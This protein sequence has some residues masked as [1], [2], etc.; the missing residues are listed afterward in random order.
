MIRSFFLLSSASLLLTIGVLRAQAP[1]APANIPYAD[2]R[3]ILDVLRSDLLPPELRAATPV[4]RQAI[5]PDWVARRDGDIRARL[6]RADEDSLLNLLLLGTTFTRHP[7]VTD[8][9]AVRTREAALERLA[10]RLDDLADA[11]TSPRDERLRFARD[12][13]LGRGI[14]AD[15]AQGKSQIR[16]YLLEI[17]ERVAGETEGFARTAAAMS[18]LDDPVARLALSATNYRD[19]G[20]SSD[21]S[22]VPNFAVDRALDD[23]HAA[24]R[25]R[26]RSIRRVALIGPG[27][28]VID[29][30]DG[31]DF[32]P[33]QTI[34]PFALVDSLVRLGLAVPDGL[35]IATFDV[36]ARVNGHLEA[37]RERARSGRGYLVHVALGG[38]ERWSTELTAY[39][40]RVGMRVGDAAAAAPP[41]GSGVRVRAIQVRPAVVLSV[42]PQDLNI[43]LQRLDPLAPAERFDLVVAT[44]VFIYYDVF[45][46]SL[47][48]ANVA[49]MLRPGGL[50]LSNTLLT[51]LPGLPM[52]RVAH[53]DVVYTDTAVGD[54]VMAYERT[55]SW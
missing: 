38:R 40:A 44:N 28:D 32:Y 1:A 37:A 2:A 8:L 13:I 39:W 27:L 10:G 36:S 34:Q 11:L 41:A 23:L 42:V 26:P 20:L 19:R 54:R 51:E 18:Q 17:L 16:E 53:T 47:A 46:Q 45:E 9:A 43:V 33:V 22:L 14:D 49:R 5:W 25:L 30:R 21:T 55:G 15:R 35:Q 24:G 31:Y 7:R 4:E 12:V 29:R 52:A 3:S 48:L 50:L 6:A